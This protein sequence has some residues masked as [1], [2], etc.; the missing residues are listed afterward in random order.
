MEDFIK[1][2]GKPFFA[3]LLRRLYDDYVRNMAEWDS[4]MGII[5]PPR[6]HSTMLALGEHGAMTLTEIA[7]LLRQSHPLVL[8]WVRQLKELGLLASEADPNDRRR[9]IL[10]LTPEG[11]AELERTRKVDAVVGLAFDSLM[12]DCGANVFDT[13]WRMEEE[14][15]REPFIERLRREADRAGVRPLSR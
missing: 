13:L 15:R 1:R 14:G 9:T 6:T 2:Q 12:T 4:E 7:A 5:A 11:A 8:T 10:R 3:H